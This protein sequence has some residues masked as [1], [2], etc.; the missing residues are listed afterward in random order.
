M[1]IA[2]QKTRKTG[3]NI[4]RIDYRP[5]YKDHWLW[6]TISRWK[7]WVTWCQWALMNTLNGLRRSKDSGISSMIFATMRSWKSKTRSNRTASISESWLSTIYLNSMLMLMITK[8]WPES[9]IKKPTWARL[10]KTNQT[11]RKCSN[12]NSALDRRLIA[13]LSSKP[14]A[15]TIT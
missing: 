13:R 7:L 15:F 5:R 14:G 9:S 1:L 8:H 3:R 10:S 2:P 6:N 11:S 4:I 12:R